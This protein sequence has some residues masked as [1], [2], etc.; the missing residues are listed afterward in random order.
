MRPFALSFTLATL[1]LSH[2]TSA[3]PQKRDYSK[4][5]QTANDA[6]AALAHVN[7][8]IKTEMVTSP[9]K[10]TKR[11]TITRQ[12][13]DTTLTLMN[14]VWITVFFE[15]TETGLVIIPGSEVEGPD[16]VTSLHVTATRT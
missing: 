3:L 14:V 4:A 2:Q 11:Q 16:P 6:A 12:N 13:Y 15:D 10:T 7:S 5:I 1:L 9:P 8:F